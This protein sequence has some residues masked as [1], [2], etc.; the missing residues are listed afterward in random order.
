ML[1]TFCS[2]DLENWSYTHLLENRECPIFVGGDYI[3]TKSR[4]GLVQTTPSH[5]QEDFLTSMKYKLLVLSLV[6]DN[7]KYT[8]KLGNLLVWISWVMEIWQ[9]SRV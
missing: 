7:G 8:K 1:G 3:T 9:L 6:D 2:S 5:G 4:I